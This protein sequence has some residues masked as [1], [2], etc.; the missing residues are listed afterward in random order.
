LA[1]PAPALAACLTSLAKIAARAPDAEGQVIWWDAGEWS[2]QEED[3]AMLDAEE[4]A[5][6][7]EGL[8]SEGFGLHWQALAEPD[9]PARPV[10]I[11]LFFWQPGEA[12]PLPAAEGWHLA[13]SGTQGATQD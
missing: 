2:A 11:R 6:Y 1:R 4:V 8:L 7:A 12:P 5:F 10:L 13:G 3:E 9:E